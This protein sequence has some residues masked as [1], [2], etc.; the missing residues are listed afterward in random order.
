MDR[1]DY[2][3]DFINRQRI[4]AVTEIGV[5]RGQFAEHMLTH[6]PGIEQYNLVDPWRHLDDWNKP[7]NVDPQEFEDVY[8]EARL[9]TAPFSSKCKFLRGRTTEIDLPIVDFTYV[10][11]DHTL[12]GITI[13]LIRA[14]PKTTWLGGDDFGEIWAHGPNHEPSLVKPFAVYFA[15]AVDAPFLLDGDQFLIGGEDG[16]S[17]PETFGLLSST[18]PRK[19]RRFLNRKVDFA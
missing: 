1:F 19:R 7:F 8:A 6:C 5:W 2:W 9:R 4:K 11:G 10:D 17:F 3:A 16:F 14:W 18:A 15:E 12:R 13:D